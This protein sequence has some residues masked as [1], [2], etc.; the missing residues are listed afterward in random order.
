MI[1]DKNNNK[2]KIIKSTFIS[3]SFLFILITILTIIAILD[4]DFSS[5]IFS[6]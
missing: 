1:S 2:M 3:S 5:N 4:I 6:R